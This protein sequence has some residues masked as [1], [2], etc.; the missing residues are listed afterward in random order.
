MRGPVDVLKFVR[1]V[2]TALVFGLGL[3]LAGV[4]PGQAATAAQISLSPASGPAG[5]A[6][7][8]AG[9]GFRASTS[10]TV[11]AG[12][13]AFSF[14]TT[15]TGAFSTPITIPAASTG[16][17]RV[18]AKTSSVQATALYTVAAPTAALPP[19]S[20]AALRFGVA[21]AN[22][23][24]ASA[25][26]DQVSQAAG[27]SPSSILFYKDFLQPAPIS[28]MNAARARGAVPLVTWEP[29]AWGGNG[30]SQPAYALNRITAGDFD[31]YIAQ[32]GRDLAS[33]GT[34]CNCG[35]PTK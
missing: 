9:T 31:S 20:P 33:G 23:P 6:V 15:P 8:V 11:V 34:P 28:E 35:S 3:T 22:G 10:G 17:V 25:E 24:L 21:T 2:S 16:Q 12:S 7:T 27:E 29:W 32:W 14:R 5:S 4:Q 13:T 30:A 19:V 18:T 1:L 26:L